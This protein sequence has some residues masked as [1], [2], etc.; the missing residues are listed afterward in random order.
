MSQSGGGGGGGPKRPR[1]ESYEGVSLQA[2]LI[3][4]LSLALPGTPGPRLS[5][6][7]AVLTTK[8]QVTLSEP[9][10]AYLSLELLSIGRA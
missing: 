2:L 10:V 3:C 6:N 9:P 8:P 7:L 5:A 4:S 1:T